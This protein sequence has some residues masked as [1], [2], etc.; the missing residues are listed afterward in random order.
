MTSAQKP[1]LVGRTAVLLVITYLLV[2]GGTLNGVVSLALQTVSLALLTVVVLVWAVI[3]LR[4]PLGGWPPLGAA[5][6]AWAA[7]ITLSTLTN[8]SGRAQ[9]GAWYAALYAGVWL[10]LADLRARGLPGCWLTDGALLAV[11][12][13]MLVAL[14]QAAPWYATWLRLDGVEIPFAPLRPPATLGNPNVLGAVLALLL[15]LGIVRARWSARRPD[16]VLWAGWVVLNGVAL[17]LTFSRGA[18]LGA[19]IGV[20]TL[21][22]PYVPRSW[23]SRLLLA[24][25][26]VLLVVIALVAIWPPGMF[27]NSRR[28]MDGRLLFYDVAADSFLDHPLTGTGLFTF[29]L[30]LL[31]ERSTPPSQPHAHAHNLPLNVA[32]ELGLP[33]LVALAITAMLVIRQGV[34]AWSAAVDTPERAQ[35]AA[36]LSGTVGWFAHQLVDVPALTPVVFLLLLMV[37]AAGLEPGS[38]PAALPRRRINARSLVIFALW[39]AV[40]GAGWWSNRV[41]AEYIRGARQ[42]VGGDA[43]AG[44]GALRRA[45]ERHPQIALYHAAHGYACGLAAASGETD[46]LA[47]GIAAYERALA[48]E[49]PHAVW[50]ANLSALYAQADQ[51]EQATR[52]AERAADYAP[53]YAGF[54]L[55]LGALAEQDDQPARAAEAY[56]RALEIDPYWGHHDAFWQKNALRR[57]V[58]AAANVEPLPLDRAKQLWFEG[59]EDAARAT[60]QAAIDRDPAELVPY[61]DFGLFWVWTGN[62]AHAD[63]YVAAARLLAT[64][65]L[66]YAR[67]DYLAAQIAVA[68]G[69]MTRADE[70]LEQARVRILPDETGIPL[71]QGR[72]VAHMQFLRAAWRGS[73]LPQLDF[74]SFDPVLV[75]LLEEGL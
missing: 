15:P 30:T 2:I 59:Q 46:L 29:G 56:R 7:A 48:L 9:I 6:I 41:Y 8:W 53:D 25:G 36:C 10:L 63:D 32:A 67:V 27:D 66:E 51:P 17:L 28:D 71:F 61:V 19:G 13:L 26:A 43:A 42:V 73:L 12:P 22:L 55:N 5:L 72:D 35:V 23:W 20:I 21:V 33:G 62:L 14:V 52:A 74:L 65:D 50:W 68:K 75:T 58:L 16:R 34:R 11:V 54:W 49:A 45:A 70:L 37:L 44:I 69:D 60:L 38:R 40:L 47:Q 31:G 3:A 64:N 1:S 24:G 18:W 4:C 57:E 39:L